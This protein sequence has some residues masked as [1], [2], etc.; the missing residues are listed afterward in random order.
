M[1]ETTRRMGAIDGN[2]FD[3]SSSLGRGNECGVFMCQFFCIFLGRFGNNDCVLRSK[4]F[5]V[6]DLHFL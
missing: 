2:R 4:N 6:F 3:Y 1:A 5:I